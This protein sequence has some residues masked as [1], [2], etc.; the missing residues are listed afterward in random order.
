MLQKSLGQG[1]AIVN[2]GKGAATIIDGTLRPYHKIEQY[3]QAITSN[4]D[5]VIIMLGTN[6]ANPKWWDDADRP[7]EFNGTPAQEFKAGLIKLI[8]DFQGL[9]SNPEVILATPLPIFP[10]KTKAGMLAERIGRNAH[11]V[12]NIIPIIKTVAH[13]QQLSLIDINTKMADQEENCRDGVH[14]KAEGYQMMTELFKQA[15]VAKS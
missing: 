6:D 10:N 13:E 9:P 14:Y 8:Q 3:Q 5:K 4:P 2:A 1:W 7:T 11:L 15:L 12:N